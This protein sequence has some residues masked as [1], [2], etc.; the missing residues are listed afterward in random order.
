MEIIGFGIIFMVVRKLPSGSFNPLEAS[1]VNN[2]S[3]EFNEQF[4]ETT[5]QRYK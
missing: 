5:L 3:S 2:A 4:P 1:M